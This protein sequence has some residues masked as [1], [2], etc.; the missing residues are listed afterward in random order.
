M[1]PAF[2]AALKA[3]EETAKKEQEARDAEL[4]AKLAAEDD[5]GAGGAAGGA[6]GA[7]GGAAGAEDIPIYNIDEIFS[8]DG[9]DILSMH[10]IVD[11][12][13]DGNCFYYAVYHSLRCINPN[14]MLN[15]GKKI[16]NATY[17]EFFDHL[18][19][20]L[21]E[22]KYKDVHSNVSLSIG[23][24]N[25]Y[26]DRP[27]IF[28]I[29]NALHINI[30]VISFTADSFNVTNYRNNNEEQTDNNTVS[31][32]H[33]GSHFLT[34]LDTTKCFDY[35]ISLSDNFKLPEQLQ[36]EIKIIYEQLRINQ[37]ILN[38]MKQIRDGMSEEEINRILNG[39]IKEETKTDKIIID[40]DMKKAIEESKKTEKEE[41]IRR[42]TNEKD[43][44]ENTIKLIA[45]SL[46]VSTKTDIINILKLIDEHVVFGTKPFITGLRVQ[47]NELTNKLARLVDEKKYYKKYIKYKNKYLLL[48]SKSN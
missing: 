6:G 13:G 45:E 23:D 26:A 16:S 14:F 25:T 18:R 33:H 19:R 8:E 9:G 2:I 48:R 20:I 7:A 17:D 5:G 34:L 4:A 30:R 44:L 36:N 24:R 27:S 29:C 31:I 35:I 42:I 38:K 10:Q 43:E 12:E 40:D 39:F 11:V 15:I 32:V 47:Y 1:D 22:P 3:S 41:N 21:E 28:W 46:G 37:E